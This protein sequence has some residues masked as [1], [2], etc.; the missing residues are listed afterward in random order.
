MG[1]GTHVAIEDHLDP[2]LW[3]VVEL[4]ADA[5]KLVEFAVALPT[6]D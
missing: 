4:I 5:W 6:V 2:L 3:G 1:I